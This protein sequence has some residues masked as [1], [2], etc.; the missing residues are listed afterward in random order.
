MNSKKKKR[1]FRFLKIFFAE[2]SACLMFAHTFCF[3]TIMFDI[4]TAKCSEYI[5]HNYICLLKNYDSLKKQNFCGKKVSQ[6]IFCTT[7]R[8]PCARHANKINFLNYKC[9]EVFPIL[10]FIAIKIKKVMN[11]PRGEGQMHVTWT[12]LILKCPISMTLS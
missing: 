5:F 10:F 3:L 1:F 6:T 11:M 4:W 2:I 12:P 8:V 7:R 9:T